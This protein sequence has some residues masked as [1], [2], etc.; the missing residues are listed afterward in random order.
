[1]DIT[2][3]TTGADLIEALKDERA[4]LVPAWLQ[5]RPNE[6]TRRSY[7]RG[8]KCFFGTEVVN[9]HL[10]ASVNFLQVNEWI[11]G[12]KNDGLSPATVAQRVNSVRSFY[13]FIEAA[14]LLNQNPLNPHLVTGVRVPKKS[15]SL[16]E[17]LDR[18]QAKRLIEAARQSERTGLRDVAMIETL[19]FC[20]LRR[21]ALVAMD[22]EHIRLAGAYWV[23]D[24]PKAKGGIKRWVDIPAR[25]VD[26]IEAYKADAGITSGALWLSASNR[27]R[28]H[29]L[30][31]DGVLRIVTAIAARAGLPHTWVHKLRHTGATLAINGGAP[32][33]KAQSRLGHSDLN[34]TM[35]YVHQGDK[36]ENSAVNYMG[37]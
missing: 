15:D 3:Q 13:N 8:I 24:I 28:G 7:L 2:R 36:L 5:R 20:W 4:N 33:E 27:R 32:I 10:A 16:V 34:T 31:P 25:V 17:F 19:L 11:Q 1:M 12:L 6:N 37:I 21:S 26:S 29:R 23:L 18:S 14:G 9:L 35:R 22:V 30:R